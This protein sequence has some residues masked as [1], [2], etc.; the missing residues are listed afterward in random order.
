MRNRFIAYLQLTAAMVTVGSTVVASNIIGR[1]LEP[2][3]AAALRFAIALPIQLAL[4]L[5]TR[6]ALPRP[7]MADAMVLI[8]QAATGS[9]GYTILLIAGT[10]RTSAADAGVII[11]TLPAVA[12]LTAAIALGERLRRATI[13]AVL[14][15][16]GGV[17]LATLGGSGHPGESRSLAGDGLVLLAVVCES[18]FILLNK[19]LSRPW[20]PLALATAMTGLGFSISLALAIPQLLHAPAALPMRPF[21]G[22]LYYALVPTVLGFWLWYAGASQVSGGEAAIFTAVAP[23]S[24]VA[25]SA[26]V[27]SEPMTPVRLGGLALVVAAV[28]FT[29]GTARVPR[30]FRAALSQASDGGEGL[31]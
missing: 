29:T 15:A 23:V 6:T 10:S 20:P 28:V 7:S 17:L 19:R 16:T 3:L 13:T 18:L 2:F 4:M 22:V 14:L 9:V 31:R 24:G 30:R 1:G 27:L 26:L 11:G 8:A 21:L 25:L 12:A 5:A